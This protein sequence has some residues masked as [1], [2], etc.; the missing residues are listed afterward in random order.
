MWVYLDIPKSLTHSDS[1]GNEWRN[2]YTATENACQQIVNCLSLP[3]QNV[4]DGM[5]M[6]NDKYA[7]L[8]II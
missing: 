6:N 7:I 3:E 8:V 2:A 5:W 1:R 4:Y